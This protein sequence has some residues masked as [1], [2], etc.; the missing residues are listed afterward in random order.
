VL[1]AVGIHPMKRLALKE[2]VDMEHN[3]EHDNELESL[4]TT[5]SQVLLLLLIA[6]IVCDS[7]CEKYFCWRFKSERTHFII[8]ES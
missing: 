7:A 5:I 1:L 3:S 8:L 4:T 6:K 2:S